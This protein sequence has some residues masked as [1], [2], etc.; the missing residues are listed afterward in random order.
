MI[1]GMKSE[2]C[3]CCEAE[4]FFFWRVFSLRDVIIVRAL[5]GN[6]RYGRWRFI[7]WKVLRISFLWVDPYTSLTKVCHLSIGGLYNG[8]LHLYYCGKC[9]SQPDWDKIEIIEKIPVLHINIVPNAGLQ[10]I[11]RA[12]IDI[13]V[14]CSLLKVDKGWYMDISHVYFKREFFLAVSC[15]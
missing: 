5:L 11:W 7:H 15:I 9:L 10:Y 12:P 1:F 3:W 4:E 14:C 13:P 8:M 2:R 6:F